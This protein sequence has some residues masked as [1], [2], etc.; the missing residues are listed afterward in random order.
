MKIEKI[1]KLNRDKHWNEVVKVKKNDKKE[2]D[3]GEVLSK[4]IE[5]RK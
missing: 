5:N 1:P 4:A 2:S 3:F